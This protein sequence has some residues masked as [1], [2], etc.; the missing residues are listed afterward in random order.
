MGGGDPDILPGGVTERLDLRELCDGVLEPRDGVLDSTR[1]ANVGLTRGGLISSSVSQAA[2]LAA[3][4]DVSS[5]IET[6]SKFAQE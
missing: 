5:P 6:K 2:M 3:N 1:A 4:G